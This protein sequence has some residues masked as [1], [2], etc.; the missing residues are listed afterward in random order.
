MY[1]ENLMPNAMDRLCRRLGDEAFSIGGLPIN[2]QFTTTDE[3]DSACHPMAA[4]GLNLTPHA[5]RGSAYPGRP[6]PGGAAVFRRTACIIM[7]LMAFG[8]AMSAEGGSMAQ[9][10]AVEATVTGNDQQ[11][12]FR[13]LV[14]KQAIEY[15]LAG[16]ARNDANE[17]V[18]F[19]L[20]GDKQRIDLA[21]ATVQ[22]GTKK[23]SDIK[24]KTTS[25]AIDP[26]L[27]AFTIVDWT[28]SSRNITNKY[29]L[30]FEL[31]AHDAKISPADAKAAWRQILETTLNADDQ[32]KLRPDD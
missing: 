13:A 14:M 26:D 29:N 5:R 9:R 1:N 27:N 22:K 16:S 17:I 30:V 28:S 31:R 15:N 18:H 32:K 10:K 2:P 8:F 4:D 7:M 25:A 19:T 12:G 6:A 23:S 20:Q 11:V 21:L 3:L 24:I